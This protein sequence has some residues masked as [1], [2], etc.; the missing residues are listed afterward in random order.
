MRSISAAAAA[1]GRV[2]QRD[3]YHQIP[4]AHLRDIF[5]FTDYPSCPCAVLFDR[6]GHVYIKYLVHLVSDTH[7]LLLIEQQ[8]A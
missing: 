5:S 7:L 4:I 6:R 1:M 8:T 2:D 3:I